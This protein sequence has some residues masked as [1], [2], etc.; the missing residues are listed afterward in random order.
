MGNAEARTGGR[1]ACNMHPRLHERDA[2][3]PW[4]GVAHTCEGFI[5]L[6]YWYPNED[7]PAQECV[8][9]GALVVD[10][11]QHDKFHNSIDLALS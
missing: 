6:N 11:D 4:E 5:V 10:T 9:C 3:Y 8:R 7:A 1:G 2:G